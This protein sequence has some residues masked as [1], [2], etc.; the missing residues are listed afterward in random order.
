M[1]KSASPDA[2]LRPEVIRL[3]GQPVDKTPDLLMLQQHFTLVIVLRKLHLGERRVDFAMTG[4]ADPQDAA[5]QLLS[6][7]TAPD[8]LAPVEGARDKV[9]TG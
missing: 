9:M 4:T 5:M 1:A 2:F 6:T 3:A 8:A 7:E